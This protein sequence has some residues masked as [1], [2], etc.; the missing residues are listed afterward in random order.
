MKKKDK[1]PRAVVEFSEH[2]DDFE[3]SVDGT[4]LG[5]RY[6]YLDRG[7]FHKLTSFFAHN[8]IAP[9]IAYFYSRIILRDK[10]IGKRNFKGHKSLIMYCNHTEPVGDALAPHTFV[11]PKPAY[12][13]VHP[14]NLALPVLGRLIPYLGAI[15]T[16]VDL[17]T[18]KSFS[19]CLEYRLKRGSALVIFPE[20]H[21]WKKYTGIRPMDDGAFSFPGKYSAPAF[22]VTRV[23]RRARLFGARCHIYIDGPYYEDKTLSRSEARA[24]LK[25]EITEKMK[26][27][28]ALSDIEIIRY[29]KKEN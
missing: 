2:T 24:K 5:R 29:I 23:Y 1:Y 13:V 11:F 21:V 12:T 16:P 28:A 8:I 20:A 22:A 9:P 15:P 17:A 18:S 14:D 4:E 27:R 7:F 19:R 10:L 26:E 6:K 3:A 25:A